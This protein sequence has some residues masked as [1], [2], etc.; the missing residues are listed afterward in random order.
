MDKKKFV[1]GWEH[2]CKTINF[3]ASFLD[4]QAIKFMNDFK[5]HIDTLV[6]RKKYDDRLLTV[7]ELRDILAQMYNNLPEDDEELLKTVKNMH[8]EVKTNG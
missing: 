7:G 3:K 8:K 2:F 1:E 6:D 5:H 4:A